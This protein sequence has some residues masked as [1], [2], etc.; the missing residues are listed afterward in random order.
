M[1]GQLR[2]SD[3]KAVSVGDICIEKIG[4]VNPSK[5]PNT[6]FTYVDI[7]S[8]DNHAKIISSPQNLLGI[9]A[10]S[11]ARRLI[12]TGDV[13]ISMTRPNL[14]AVAMVPDWLDGQVCST[15]FCVL[16][17]NKSVIP[18]YVFHF[19]R[20]KGFVEH[21][22]GLVS[23]ALYPAVTE[24]QVRDTPLLLPPLSEQRRIVDILNHAASVR[25]LRDEARAKLREIIPAL[26]VEMFGDPITNPKGWDVATVGNVIDAADYGTS[27]KASDMP[28]GTPVLRMGNVSASGELLL[29]NLK[30]L[31]LSQ[32]EHSKLRLEVGDIL[33]NRTNSKDLVG[34]TGLWSGQF[35]AV[36]ASYFI[37]IRVNRS[38][39]CPT[40]FWSYF[41]SKFMKSRLYET[42]RGAIGQANINTKE[43]KA[44]NIPVPPLALQQEFAD[45]VADIESAAALSD[46]AVAVAEQLTQSLLAQVFGATACAETPELCAP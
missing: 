15:G 16:R 43:L 45:R 8:V 32:E 12:K 11:R 22:T 37:R 19:A 25:R 35:E 41:N 24:G 1:L 42:A 21:L 6:R 44:F 14:N 3:W 46:K 40:Y 23:G 33:F 39:I 2:K 4:T 28:V 20:S 31:S 13:I 26:F 27:T 29:E 30:Y 18:E 38:I 36:A 7:A 5:A 9:D 10:P 17:A 34:K